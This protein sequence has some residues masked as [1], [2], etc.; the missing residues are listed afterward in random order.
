[1]LNSIRIYKKK[2]NSIF[3]KPDSHPEGFYR[4]AEDKPDFIQPWRNDYLEGRMMSALRFRSEKRVK[5]KRES[6]Q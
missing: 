1:L 6:Q 5:K 4:N 2:K 3:R